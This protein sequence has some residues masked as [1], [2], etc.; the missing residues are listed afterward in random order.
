MIDDAG[1]QVDGRTDRVHLF[2]QQVE[3]VDAQATVDAQK[4]GVIGH[5]VGGQ[6][7]AEHCVQAFHVRHPF[8]VPF[9]F[10]E[11]CKVELRV[12]LTF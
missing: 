11:I 7:L 10:V 8:F 4:F 5:G 2:V 9:D 12:R 6:I 1:G 3:A